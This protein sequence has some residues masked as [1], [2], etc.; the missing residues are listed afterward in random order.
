MAVA[1]TGP[2]VSNR[3]AARSSTAP[4]SVTATGLPNA[5]TLRDP[6]QVRP[7]RR[8]ARLSAGFAEVLVIKNQDSEIV[9]RLVGDDAE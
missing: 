1:N 6:A 7:V 9:R 4:C 3:K 2:G 5:K 8:E